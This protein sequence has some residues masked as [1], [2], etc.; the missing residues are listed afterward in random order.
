MLPLFPNV[1][2]NGKV[3]SV[4][5]KRASKTSAMRSPLESRSCSPL[6]QEESIGESEVLGRAWGS[7]ATVL[8]VTKISSIFQLVLVIAKEQECK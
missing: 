2:G 1:D 4:E 7:L 8:A 3:S 5:W 6:E